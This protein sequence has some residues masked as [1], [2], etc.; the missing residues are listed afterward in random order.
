MTAYNHGINFA[1]KLT[2]WPIMV[3]EKCEILMIVRHYIIEMCFKKH[4][5]NKVKIEVA[6]VHEKS[7]LCH[8]QRSSECKILQCN[9]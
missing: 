9:H 2:N 6:K 5:K 4:L 8:C 3:F 7:T 1:A